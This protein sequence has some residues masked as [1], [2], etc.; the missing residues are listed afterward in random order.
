MQKGLR[1]DRGVKGAQDTATAPSSVAGG[2]RRL[3]ALVVRRAHAVRNKALVQ[4]NCSASAPRGG[5][6]VFA[7]YHTSLLGLISSAFLLTCGHPL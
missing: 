2:D 5:E 1:A 3:D 4:Q 6:G 7:S